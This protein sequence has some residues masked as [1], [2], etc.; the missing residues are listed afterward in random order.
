MSA[1][2]CREQDGDPAWQSEAA[3]EITNSEVR[4]DGSPWGE[5]PVRTAYAASTAFLFA[6]LDALMA[7]RD[8]VNVSSTSYVPGVLS[9]AAMEAGS[10]A[11]WL[12]EPGISARHRVIRSVLVRAGSAANL[13]ETVEAVDPKASISDYGEDPAM[14]EAYSRAPGIA[15]TLKKISTAEKHWSVRETGFPAILPAPLRWKRPCE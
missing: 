4:A 15:Y 10:Q 3:C 8:S 5:T 14:V 12:L 7:L 6:G 11:F 13:K 1:G 2:D 9:R